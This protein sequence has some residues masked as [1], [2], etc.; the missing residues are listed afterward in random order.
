MHYALQPLLKK[1]AQGLRI[2]ASAPLAAFAGVASESDSVSSTNNQDKKNN[3]HLKNRSH[4]NNKNN[5]NVIYICIY[6]H[7]S[8]NIMALNK[9]PN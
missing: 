2:R 7:I 3:K 4:N 6:I 9:T 8:S 1:Y 5:D